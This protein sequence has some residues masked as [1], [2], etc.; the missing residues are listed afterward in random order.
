MANNQSTFDPHP[1]SAILAGYWFALVALIGT[2]PNIFIII[3]TFRMPKQKFN[4]VYYIISA[5]SVADCTLLLGFAT[6]L[7]Y[8]L[9]HN[10]TICKCGG[11]MVYLGGMSNT[12]IPVLMAWNRH[13]IM[14]NTRF[15][16]SQHA[17]IHI[18]IYSSNH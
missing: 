4:P 10:L 2:P 7:P 17:C 16:V 13:A 6:G 14:C 15:Q 18:D 8:A 11:A 5:L 1:P 9:L 12:I 3:A